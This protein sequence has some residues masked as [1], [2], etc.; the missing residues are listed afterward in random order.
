MPLHAKTTSMSVPLRKAWTQE[1]FFAWAQQQA[2][3][4][5]FDGFEPVAMTGGTRSHG[6]ISRNLLIQLTAKLAGSPCEPTGSDGAGV[7][8]I[9]KHVRY[10][11]AVVSCN[12]SETDPHRVQD[13]VVVFEVLS[14]STR[15]TDQIEKLREYE[16]VST[17]KK[18]ILIEQTEIAIAVHSRHPS[19]GWTIPADIKRAGETLII[20][21]IGIELDINPL[22]EGVKF[23]ET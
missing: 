12:P 9:N 21:E 2:G 15:Y 22:Y 17:I 8:T 1:E 6:I 5:E 4:Y 11:E 3:R 10:P 16:A 19:G 20:P 14:P 13:P 7:A 23:R 18:Y